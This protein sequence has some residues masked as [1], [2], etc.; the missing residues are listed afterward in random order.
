MPMSATIPLPTSPSNQSTHV[1]P[2]N[3]YFT[4]TGATALR[5]WTTSGVRERVVNFPAALLTQ[6]PDA[7]A[8]I[9]LS[10][11]STT[12]VR[13][14]D[15][16]SEPA[17]VGI[18]PQFLSTAEA[19]LFNAFRAMPL[20]P[21]GDWR[22]AEGVFSETYQATF[23]ALLRMLRQPPEARWCVRGEPGW[24]LQFGLR[25]TDGSYTMGAFVLPCGK[26]AVLTFRA[27]DLI[28]TLP[29]ERPFAE[30]DVITVA[31]GLPEQKNAALV[32]DTRIRLPIADRGA[33]L[34]RLLPTYA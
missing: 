23:A 3:L 25:E 26:P 5:Y 16:S 12:N 30:M 20:K 9:T 19:V 4:P 29:P 18:T 10:D 21:D 28:Q 15:T 27:E 24:F 8:L 6:P 33:A 11:H 22:L 2:T 7:T 14:R 13:A 32:W 1:F 31:D 34:I 17:T